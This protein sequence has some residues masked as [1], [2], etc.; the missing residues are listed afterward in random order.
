MKLMTTAGGVLLLAGVYSGAQ[1]V[2]QGVAMVPARRHFDHVVIVVLENTGYHEA[3]GDPE[4]QALRRQ[5]AWLTDYHA[6]THPSFPNYL[7][8]IAGQ[9][10]GVRSDDQPAPGFDIPT[11]ADALERRGLADRDVLDLVRG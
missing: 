8:L 1:A 2:P 11:I 5:G 6:I 10:H 4:L 9:T 7:A 3:L